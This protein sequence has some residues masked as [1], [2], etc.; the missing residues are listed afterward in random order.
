MPQ[1]PLFILLY[2]VRGFRQ[3]SSSVR[4]FFR[5]WPIIHEVCMRSLLSAVNIKK[6]S[7]RD[8]WGFSLPP[9][10]AGA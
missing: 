4:S 3:K 7:Q 5:Y 2:P 6:K 8:E 1:I 9:Q 10:W